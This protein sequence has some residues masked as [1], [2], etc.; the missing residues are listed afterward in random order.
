MF[1][2]FSWN[3]VVQVRISAFDFGNYVCDYHQYV[4]H[5]QSSS[6][7]CGRSRFKSLLFLIQSSLSCITWRH[8][9][10]ELEYGSP[11]SNHATGQACQARAQVYVNIFICRLL[12]WC[13]SVQRMQLGITVMMKFHLIKNTLLMY[14]CINSK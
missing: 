4:H 1:W 10:H 8:P 6:T 5:T 12:L 9:G 7:K 2:L 3:W 11:V 14:M 13:S